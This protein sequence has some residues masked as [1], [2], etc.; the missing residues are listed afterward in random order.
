MRR[1]RRGVTEID[2]EQAL[3][4]RADAERAS[5]VPCLEEHPRVSEG[6]LTSSLDVDGNNL[7]T[8]AVNDLSPVRMP[9]R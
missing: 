4:V 3:S 2:E 5:D 7:V 9:P 6:E 8:A 1:G